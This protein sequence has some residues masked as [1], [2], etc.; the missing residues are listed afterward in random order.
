V[1]S[2]SESRV[3]GLEDISFTVNV[4]ERDWNQLR[5]AI[6]GMPAGSGFVGGVSYLNG[7]TEFEAAARISTRFFTQFDATL[8]FPTGQSDV[9]LRAEAG[10]RSSDFR[11]LRFLVS[12]PRRG[13]VTG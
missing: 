11:G 5:P 7:S 4:F 1:V 2:D 8:R 6:G 13:R 9:P 10:V 12:V 3:L